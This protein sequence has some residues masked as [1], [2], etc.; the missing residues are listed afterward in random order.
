MDLTAAHWIYLIAMVVII[1]V[2]ICRKNIVVPAVAATFLT[3]WVYTG[4]LATGLSSV[5]NASLV[6]ASEL[7]SIFLII[8]LITALL[9][10]LRAMGADQRMVLPFQKLMRNGTTAFLIIFGVTYLISLFFWPTPAVPLI[11]AILLPAAIRAGLPAMA[12]A[13]AIAVAGQGMALSSDYVIQVAPGMSATAAGVDTGAVADRAMVLSLITGAVAITMIFLKIRKQ[14][15]APNPALLEAWER[16]GEDGTLV[17]ELAEAKI[18]V[19]AGVGGSG[20]SGGSGGDDKGRPSIPASGRAGAPTLDYGDDPADGV[21]VKRAKLFSV[22]VP[23]VFA[24]LVVYMGLG[25]FTSL[26]PETT[27][28]D[29][30]GLVGGTAALLLLITTITLDGRNSLETCATHVVDGLVFAFKAMGV[31]IPIAGFFFIGNSDFAGRIM[32]LDE[33]ETAPGFLFDLV[34]Q[35][36]DSIPNVPVVMGLGI[37]LIGMATG[38]DGSG[39]S[40]LPLTGSLS[41][42]LGPASGVDPETL[43]AIGQMGAIW[44]GGG[45]LIAWSSLL[46]VA[47]FCRVSV[48]ELVRQLFLPVVTG[49]LIATVVGVLIF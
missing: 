36:Q 34:A 22:L 25:K 24:G 43:A 49:L 26:V 20:G 41:G 19:G 40:G 11:G 4:N 48:L 17:E 35:V 44:T 2:M 18:E 31:V 39:F 23:V 29:A 3:A 21:P 42:A 38:L 47:G 14:I 5:F 28:G 8:A 12:G 1:A 37:L 32:S 45:T 30:A 46:A 27:G 13:M 33:G 15:V 6:A 10:G 9:G 7:F 16:I